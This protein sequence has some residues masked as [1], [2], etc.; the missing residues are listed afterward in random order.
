MQ[1]S[2]TTNKNGVIQRIEK[3]TGLGSG[4]ISGNSTLL[5]IITASVNDAFDELMPLILSYS[6]KLRFD[7]INHTDL[8]V[9]TVNLV[10]G[11][12]DYSFTEDDNSLDILNITD[13]RI[14]TSATATAY[15]DLKR[16]YLDDVLAPRAMSPDSTET[17]VPTH[18]LEF[19]NSIFFY[20][21]PN[22]AATNGIKIYFER[23]QSY[24]V[25][26]DTT[27][28]A[29][30]PKPFHRLLPLIASHEWIIENKPSNTVLI[31]RLETKIAEAKKALK[32]LISARNPTKL[33]WSM[34]TIDYV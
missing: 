13:V 33:R 6:D 1:F 15:S 2:D 4:S 3:Y 29:G 31:T 11:Q 18:W 7:D 26:S 19:N 30:I 32:E 24:F 21:E 20:P 28:E 10:S 27:K 14:L 25:S 16:M 23:E 9:G 12:G 22:Y 17:G 8:P 34:A 5:Q